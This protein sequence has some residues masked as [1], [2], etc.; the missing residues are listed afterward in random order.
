MQGPSKTSERWGQREHNAKIV[1]D[2]FCWGK[3]KS[4]CT[5]VNNRSRQ[6]TERELEATRKPVI[7]AGRRPITVNSDCLLLF[8][9]CYVQEN[10][11]FVHLFFQWHS[12]LEESDRINSLM[13][14]N[15]SEHP[16]WYLSKALVNCRHAVSDNQ[17][18]VTHDVKGEKSD[19][20]MSRWRVSVGGYLEKYDSNVSFKNQHVCNVWC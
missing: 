13:I 2:F 18:F 6:G 17:Y 11:T 14:T 9:S 20:I 12:I 19:L 8:D 16:H 10:Q 15:F 1:R 3:S 7:C 5:C 4:V